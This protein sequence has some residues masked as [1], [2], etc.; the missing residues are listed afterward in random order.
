M[1]KCPNCGQVTDGTDCH[2]CKY[3]LRPLRLQKNQEVSEAVEAEKADRQTSIG[4]IEKAAHDL[5][6]AKKALETEIAAWE[7]NRQEA[8]ESKKAAEAE[9]ARKAA[10]AEEIAILEAE[11]ARKVAEAEEA[12][13]SE[14]SEETGEAEAAGKPEEISNSSE[15]IKKALPG[16][17]E[18]RV[19]LDSDLAPGVVSDDSTPVVAEVPHPK[20]YREIV[21]PI[22]SMPVTPGQY[23]KLEKYLETVESINRDLNKKS[24]KTE[25]AIK[26]GGF[27]MSLQILLAFDNDFDLFAGRK[28][29]FLS[30]VK[31]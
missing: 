11:E 18:V 24:I 2:W 26:D 12:K 16:T 14:E 3:P 23:K 30:F 19:V 5:E 28:R 7:K 17:E 15:P 29:I 21:E 4:V 9:E 10:G 8:E 6:E 1:A 31:F 25:D 22:V 20:L 27:I 13:K